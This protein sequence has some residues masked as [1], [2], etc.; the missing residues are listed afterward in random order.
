M[1]VSENYFDDQQDNQGRTVMELNRIINDNR[2]GQVQVESD[3]IE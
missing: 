2:L 3:L 1:F